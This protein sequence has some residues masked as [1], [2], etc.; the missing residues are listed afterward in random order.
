MQMKDKGSSKTKSVR[1]PRSVRPVREPPRTKTSRQQTV[2]A[3]TISPPILMT[4][5][6]TIPEPK[7]LLAST[8]TTSFLEKKIRKINLR[9]RG[10]Q[11]GY[12]RIGEC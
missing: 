5:F 12:L 7:M 2:V 6:A 1:Y 4:S 10:E 8:H 9:K 11:T 3:A